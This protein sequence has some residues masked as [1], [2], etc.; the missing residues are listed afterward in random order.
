MAEI[1]GVVAPSKNTVG[2]IGDIYTNTITGQKYELLGI[3][4]ISDTDTDDI[5]NEIIKEYD[6][7]PAI[8][9]DSSGSGYPKAE[10][11]AFVNDL[12]SLLGGDL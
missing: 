1:T 7:R 4:I 5:P 11:D 12:N 8:E 3:Y 2:S 6:W 10:V 9:D